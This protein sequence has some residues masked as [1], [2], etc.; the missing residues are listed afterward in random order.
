[1]K[2]KKCCYSDSS[3][4]SDSDDSCSRFKTS[5]SCSG[6]NTRYGKYK[7]SMKKSKC[8]H[9]DSSDSDSDSCCSSSDY[10]GPSY[11][12]RGSNLKKTYINKRYGRCGGNSSDNDSCSSDSD[13]DSNYSRK[14][15]PSYFPPPSVIQKPSYFPPPSV[16][17]KPIINISAIKCPIDYKDVVASNELETCCICLTNKKCINFTDCHHTNTCYSCALVIVKSENKNCPLCRN[18]IT[19]T[20]LFVYL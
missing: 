10:S 19:N 8:S 4:D 9:S 18:V 13:S 6:S 14:S 15:K 16:I 1:M 7:N 17:Q 12:C 5:Y 11:S 3:S 20:P 2:K